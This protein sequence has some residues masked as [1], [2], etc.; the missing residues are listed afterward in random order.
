MVGSLSSVLE[1]RMLE[2]STRKEKANG[3]YLK[4]MHMLGIGLNVQSH[5]IKP[6]SVQI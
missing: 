2:L 4:L 5:P 3:R 6:F 1:A